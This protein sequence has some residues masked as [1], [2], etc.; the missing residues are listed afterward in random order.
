MPPL[1]RSFRIETH[2]HGRI[3]GHQR[4]RWA[5]VFLGK[6]QFT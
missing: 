5:T 4:C 1:N 2:F 3:A 6:A